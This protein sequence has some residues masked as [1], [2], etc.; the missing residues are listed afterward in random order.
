MILVGLGLERVLAND[1]KGAQ[2]SAFHRLKHLRQVPP[3]L[4]RNRNAPIRFK[5]GAKNVILDVLE[6]GQA[7]R[8]CAHIAAALNVVLAAQRIQSAAISPDMS[9]KQSEIDER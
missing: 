6:S 1:V 7:I 9:G 8:Q 2:F 4:W 3:F 5:F